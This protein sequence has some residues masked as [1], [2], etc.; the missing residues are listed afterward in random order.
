M[1]LTFANPFDESLAFSADIVAVYVLMILFREMK[2]DKEDYHLEKRLMKI[3]MN[4]F[5]LAFYP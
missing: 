3:L 4:E 2:F 5:A 1:L